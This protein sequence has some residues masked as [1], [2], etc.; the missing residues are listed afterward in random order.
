MHVSKLR[1]TR[2]KSSLKRKYVCSKCLAAC[3]RVPSDDSYLQCRHLLGLTYE[4]GRKRSWDL[5]VVDNE[6]SLVSKVYEGVSINLMGAFYSLLNF[7]ETDSRVIGIPSSQILMFDYSIDYSRTANISGLLCSIESCHP[8]LSDRKSVKSEVFSAEAISLEMKIILAMMDKIY[9]QIMPKGS[10]MLPKLVLTL[11]VINSVI[12]DVASFY[13]DRQ[14]EHQAE[15]DSRVRSLSSYCLTQF[16]RE[17]SDTPIAEDCGSHFLFSLNLLLIAKDTNIVIKMLKS[18]ALSIK[19]VF[20]LES[21]YDEKTI[22]KYLRAGMCNILIVHNTSTRTSKEISMLE[23]L[24]R[25]YPMTNVWLLCDKTEVDCLNKKGMMK[26]FDIV[27]N[28]ER[29]FNELALPKVDSLFSFALTGPKALPFLKVKAEKT[30][31]EKACNFKVEEILQKYYLSKRNTKSAS[32]EDLSLMAKFAYTFHFFRA[33]HLKPLEEL[34]HNLRL[35]DP[36][37]WD[38]VDVV[39]AIFLFEET[40]ANKYGSIACLIDHRS[41]HKGTFVSE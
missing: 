18:I 24:M 8:T 39:M 27:L 11:G 41:L 2:G 3:V 25:N 36:K 33:L 15:A 16:P 34:L 35:L 13:W 23:R 10:F 26:S 4:R 9:K 14:K 7:K 21:A 28:V 30:L 6:D 32:Q 22:K 12:K 37:M 31:K 38:P 40:C 5:W 29:D 19:G 1:E 17:N 20:W